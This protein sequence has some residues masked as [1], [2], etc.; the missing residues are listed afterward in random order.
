MN[1]DLKV[2]GTTVVQTMF[3]H[4]KPSAPQIKFFPKASRGSF[5]QRFQSL[6][7]S[8]RYQLGSKGCVDVEQPNN[9]ILRIEIF[10][11]LMDEKRYQERLAKIASKIPE[12]FDDD[13][14]TAEQ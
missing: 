11:G 4:G 8:D 9:A 12:G 13:G 14:D 7:G 2:D 1:G 10:Q 6:T 5:A 3:F